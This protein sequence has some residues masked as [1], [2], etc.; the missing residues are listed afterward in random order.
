MLLQDSISEF[1]RKE[2]YMTDFK[3][4]FENDWCTAEVFLE[5][6]IKPVFGDYEK[7]YDVLTESSEVKEK[8]FISGIE[9]IKH[10]ASFDLLDGNK[11]KIFDITATDNKNL[12]NNKVGIQNIVRQYVGYF[13]GFLLLFHHKNVK[14]REWRLSYVEKRG[15]A[16]EVTSAKRY[17]Y[18]LGKGNPARTIT[19]RFQA[20]EKKKDS[21][22]LQDLTDAFSVES[23][24]NEFFEKYRELYA[25]FVEYIT[26]TRYVK[27]GGKFIEKN[28][29]K[30][31]A[32]FKTQF[33]CD[34]KSVRDFVKKLMGRLVFLY[35]LQ[36][37]GWLGVPV[38]KNWGEGNQK[39]ISE[40]WQNAGKKAKENFLEEI[41][42]PL[43][44]DTLNCDRS[45]K[46]YTVPEVLGGEKIKTPYLNGGLFEKDALDEKKVKFPSELFERLF[47]FFGEYN[48]TIDEADSDEAEI[49]VAPEMLGKIF[50]NLLEDNKDKGAFYTPKEVVRYMCRESLAVFLCA[51]EKTKKI[52]EEKIRAL[53]EKNDCI[54][55][56]KNERDSILE[57]LRGIK[58]CDPAVG[59]GAFPMGML[60]ELFC[61]RR[62]LGEMD[63]QGKTAAAIKKEI[64]RENIYGVDIERGAIDIA[65]LRF[66]LSIIVDEED[67][68]PMP[69]LDYKI[70]RGNSL[71]ESFEE[72]DLSNLTCKQE[73]ELFDSP[74]TIENLIDAVNGFFV[75]RDDI[76][77]KKIR[78]QI[79]ENALA[80]IKKREISFEKQAGKK[81]KLERLKEIDLHDTDEFFL[82]HL[83]FHDVFNRPHKGQ[84]NQGGFDVVIAN[85][86]YVEARSS[87]FSDDLKIKIQKS[88][89]QHHKKEN[90]K[91]FPRGADLLIFFYELS[92][93]LLNP[94]GISVFITENAWLSTDYGKAFQKYLL[95]YIEVKGIID[96]DYKY[97]ETADINTVITFFMRKK[98]NAE[99]FVNFFH[100]HGN[101]D[102]HPCNIAFNR[103][104]DNLVEKKYFSSTNSLLTDYKWGF[105][106]SSDS[107][108]IHLLEL[109]NAKKLKSL[110]NKISI[111][112]GLNL[113]KDNITNQ[114]SPNTIPYF[115]SDY[116][117]LYCWKE[118]VCYVSK[119]VLTGKRKMPIM[120][121]PRG[122]GTHFC[123]MNECSGYTSS[124][125]EIY[126]NEK[127]TK[128][129]KLQI[130]TFCN[131]SILWLLREFTGRCN[132]GGGMLKAEATDLKTLPLCFDFNEEEMRKIYSLAQ[133]M[134]NPINIEQ[135]VNTEIHKRIDNLVFDSLSIL[136]KKNFVI[137]MLVKRINWRC[138]KSST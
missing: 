50:E 24:S 4:I 8:A 87:S 25:D 96:S 66:W 131:S 117:S 1:Q 32:Q 112:Q 124:Y 105:I 123:C 113:T 35:F 79:Q 100:V 64:V 34:E 122:I 65:R 89:E 45:E 40:L 2:P 36:K 103:N 30:A 20:L 77:K 108:L 118:P 92:F 14:N 98:E 94:K 138:K 90:K 12:A 37:K 63:G 68:I 111:G 5:K 15:R 132:L 54:S 67:P 29:G 91:Y 70:M 18:I 97:F 49:G 119:S 137:E 31:N 69:N 13:E 27:K 60:N 19:E 88:I 17:T 48:F 71:L 126:E 21:L 107:K 28:I 101:I 58:I 128:K 11:I 26:G 53:I 38:Q 135:A 52:G 76:A 136:D 56:G 22:T 16:T 106:F 62:A 83:W 104:K 72:I 109:L 134:Q 93:R 115:T 102:K 121:L 110:Q 43:F 80:L 74:E 59:S 114:K 120:F 6:V 78:R 81:T 9:E 82:W 57:K 130:W 73:G 125:V 39:W 55:L 23:L 44:F 7:G 51:D 133:G 10:C 47:E 61:L 127:L 33:K 95:K 75:P 41:L 99:S 42:E 129:E 84:V 46:N 85:P 3:S 86:P 116:G